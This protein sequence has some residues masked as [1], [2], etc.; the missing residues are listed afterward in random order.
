MLVMGGAASLNGVVVGGARHRDDRCVPAPA[1]VC[2]FRFLQHLAAAARRR[3]QQL[4][5]RCQHTV[6][7]RSVPSTH[8][9][10]DAC[11]VCGC[12]VYA[13]CLAP[14]MFTRTHSLS[15]THTPHTY[16]LTH[17]DT[18]PHTQR[19]DLQ[20]AAGG[21]AADGRT[22]HL[23]PVPRAHQRYACVYVCMYACKHMYRGCLLYSYL[24]PFLFFSLVL[25]F[26]LVVVVVLSLVLLLLFFSLV[27]LFFSLVLLLFS[28]VHL[29][30]TG[31]I[32]S[33]Y[34]TIYSNQLAFDP[35]DD[36]KVRACVY[37]LSDDVHVCL[38][39]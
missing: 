24:V 36:T 27:L 13:V 33:D 14:F 3:L 37:V 18:H 16:T 34:G 15:L 39:A 30:R 1:A 9:C 28:L 29:A 21:G 11:V 8:T 32:A 31:F 26:S 5:G 19:Q 7:F 23:R 17:C 25:S 4:C 22:A 38:C 35:T 12:C 6:R 10:D 20:H 2:Q